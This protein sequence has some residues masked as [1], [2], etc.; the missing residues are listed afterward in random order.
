MKTY[1]LKIYHS[2]HITKED[3]TDF[4]ASIYKKMQWKKL[5]FSLEH[6]GGQVLYSAEYLPESWYI[7]EPIFYSFFWD[8][9][10]VSDT[11]EMPFNSD[12]GE[13]V[14][15]YITLKN[16]WFFPFWK[17]DDKKNEFISNIFRSFEKFSIHDENVK[18]SFFIEPFS[19][20]GM[21]F[22]LTSGVKYFF[23]QLRL[24]STF[25]LYL[26]NRKV[27][28]GWKKQ[29]KEYFKE[30]LSCDL[31]SVRISL[32]V[33]SK[34]TT[35]AKRKIEYLFHNFLVFKN[36]P[37][38]EFTLSYKKTHVLLTSQELGTLCYFPENPREE[39]SLLKVNAKKLALPIG[40]P[41]FQPQVLENG[42]VFYTQSPKDITILGISDYRS[43]QVPIG[44]YDEDRL[45]HTYVIGKTGTGKS[46]FLSNLMIQDLQ[47][48]KGIAVLDPH[49]DLIEDIM[50]YI[51]EYRK[52]D[53]IIFD[54][55]DEE[56][57]FCFNPL[58]IKKTESK[59]ILAKGF[60]DIFKKFFGSNW[61]P[62]LE[63][64]LRMV[65]LALLD[66]KDATLFDIIRAL[67]DKD[68][69]YEMI[70][71]IQD[72]V[73]KNFWTQEFAAWSQQFNTEAI[74][75]ILNKVWQILSIDVLRNIFSTH[76][77]KLDLR[78]VMDTEKI[79]LIKLPKWKLQEEI[80]GFLGAMFVTKIYQAA[81]SRQSIA[82]SQRKGFYLYID[83]FQNFTTDTFS[84]ILSESRK[85]GLS[86]CVAHQ[87]LKQIPPNISDALFGNVGTLISFR[88]S[89]DDAIF[90]EKQFDTFLGTYDLSNLNQREFYAKIL[91]KWQ[92]KD[93]FS[94]RS[95]YVLDREI[96][97]LYIES[98]YQA[99]RKLY[100][101]K[102]EEAH[103]DLMTHET[104]VIQKIETFIEPLL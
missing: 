3:M 32:T 80:M 27:S 40:I 21:L 84:E 104:D 88:V 102:R 96:E 98:L 5:S 99:S 12:I 6:R 11:M 45:K 103:K 50:M 18:I 23:F 79:L 101:Q 43:I 57:P 62:R 60:I 13:S 90:L 74:M 54:P 17:I 82:S 24:F 97:P 16:N 72:N 30:K 92:V 58:D 33:R 78:D 89:S 8:S 59:Q 52:Q 9:Q 83:E 71:E 55:T 28:V 20:S 34:T 77:N 4:F 46:K 19:S 39:T 94:L 69:R 7:F 38:N 15:A 53:V 63:H 25:F 22:F 56:Y 81:M 68:F 26:L 29:G 47:K 42:E 10:I 75:P 31:A 86:L 87:F 61:N 48:G 65:F 37:L 91:V 100:A 41:N 1:L 36:Y 73:V 35:E 2:A 66:K 67:T 85:Y 93:P 49:G 14:T 95:L 51:P 44:I 70:T 76:K 64:V